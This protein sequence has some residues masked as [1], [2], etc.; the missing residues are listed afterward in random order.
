MLQDVN[1]LVIDGVEMVDVNEAAHLADRTPATIRRWVET[2]RFPAVKHG[3]KLFVPRRAVLAATGTGTELANADPLALREWAAT[4]GS[5]PAS[6]QH[7]SARDLV[8][9]HRARR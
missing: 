1:V 6:G 7:P 9:D 8:L 5:S 2:G 4:I 3:Q